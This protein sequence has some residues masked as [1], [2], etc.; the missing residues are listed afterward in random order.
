M[1]LRQQGRRNAVNPRISLPPGSYISFVAQTHP[2]CIKHS[3]NNTWL[4]F[5]KIYKAFCRSH[6]K[7]PAFVV[8][9]LADILW[10][11]SLFRIGEGLTK[12][13]RKPAITELANRGN[14]SASFPR[15]WNII[16]VVSLKQ[17]TFLQILTI[18]T[19]YLALTSSQIFCSISSKIP[20]LP[21]EQQSVTDGEPSA[22]CGHE[23]Y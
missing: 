19:P 5:I 10:W 6:L 1:W 16:T 21:G 9:S 4:F 2:F 20:Y 17:S 13:S 11:W 18:D 22:P 23:L 15:V 12:K 14:F 8:R 7:A 3:T